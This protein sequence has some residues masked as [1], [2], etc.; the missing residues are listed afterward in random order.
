MT[1]T[2]KTKDN[3]KIMTQTT[4]TKTLYDKGLLISTKRFMICTH[5][6]LIMSVHEKVKV[7]SKY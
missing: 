2:T 7:S 3:K 1:Q 4:K 5:S 6:W